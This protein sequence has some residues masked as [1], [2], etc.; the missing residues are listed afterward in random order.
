MEQGFQN[1]LTHGQTPRHVEAACEENGCQSWE[2]PGSQVSQTLAASPRSPLTFK[3]TSLDVEGHL[4]LSVQIAK[5]FS[6]LR[7]M[8]LG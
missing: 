2:D 5:P 4:S 6:E 7:I 1:L 3:R 8:K